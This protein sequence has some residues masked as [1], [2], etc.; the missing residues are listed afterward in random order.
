MSPAYIVGNPFALATI[1]ISIVGALSFDS[2]LQPELTRLQAGMVD[3]L[4]QLYYRSYQDQH[5]LQLL[6]VDIG[7]LFLLHHRHFRSIRFGRSRDL[8]R[9]STSIEAT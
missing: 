4:Y 1:S 9:S 8:P 7:V 6:L 2:S 5:V 3:R